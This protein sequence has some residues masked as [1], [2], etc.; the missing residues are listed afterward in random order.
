MYLKSLISVSFGIFLSYFHFFISFL[1]F[2]FRAYL[3]LCFCFS[4]PFLVVSLGNHFLFCAT[5]LI[6]FIP[7]GFA[8]SVITAACFATQDWFKRSEQLWKFSQLL[9][10]IGRQR[11]FNLFSGWKNYHRFFHWFFFVCFVCSIFYKS[12]K[13]IFILCFFLC[14]QK[15]NGSFIVLTGNW[16]WK[17]ELA[18][19][20]D[21]LKRNKLCM[22]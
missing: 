5:P 12:A 14:F 17:E 6:S 13:N 21:E 3:S 11:K 18:N 8:R 9:Y 19:E 1:V 16:F 2:L 10:F 20:W 22:E 7:V 4:V 15:G